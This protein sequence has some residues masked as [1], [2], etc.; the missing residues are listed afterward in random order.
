MRLQYKE[1]GIKSSIAIFL[2]NSHRTEVKALHCAVCGYVVMQYY[3][4]L[5]MFV[6]GE[7]PMELDSKP[8]AT[9]QCHN[10]QCKTLYDIYL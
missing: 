5:K 2:D 9:V 4:N 10:N 8:M 6:P 1:T 3:D 7:G